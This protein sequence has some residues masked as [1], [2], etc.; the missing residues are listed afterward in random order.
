M[1][2]GRSRNHCAFLTIWLLAVALFLVSCGT[3]SPETE[4]QTSPLAQDSPLLSPL[5][6]PTDSLAPARVRTPLEL[7]VLHTNDNWGET[8]PCG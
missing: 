6:T 4:L 5:A 8:E 3:P 2:L 1:S 7:T